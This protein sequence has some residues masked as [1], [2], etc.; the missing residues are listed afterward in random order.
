MPFEMTP[1]N[2]YNGRVLCSFPLGYISNLLFLLKRMSFDAVAAPHRALLGR[3]LAKL[4]F[5]HNNYARDE[6]NTAPLLEP[7]R[8]YECARSLCVYELFWAVVGKRRQVR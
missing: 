1:L 6:K 7:G 2:H 4:S 5:G 8:I 3:F